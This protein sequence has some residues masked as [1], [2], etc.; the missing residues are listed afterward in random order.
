VIIGLKTGANLSNVKFKNNLLAGVEQ[1]PKLSFNAGL[2]VN[3]GIKDKIL[4]RPELL[5]SMKGWQSRDYQTNSSGRVN[6]HYINIPLLVGYKPIE[7]LTILLGPEFGLLRSA[8]LKTQGLIIKTTELYNK[9]DIG[10]DLGAAYNLSSKFGVEVRYNY[11]F[12]GVSK[13]IP[14]TDENGNPFT[15]AKDG[16]NRVLQFG[17]FYLL[18]GK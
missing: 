17:V 11:G 2:L 10:V 5:Y 13:E 7:K 15:M 18:N 6:L 12:T 9:I 1:N 3:I 8:I 16:R 14:L 4:V